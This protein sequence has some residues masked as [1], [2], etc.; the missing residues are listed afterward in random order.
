MQQR[1]KTGAFAADK[2]IR[3]SVLMEPGEPA[4][5][6]YEDLIRVMG[7]SGSEVLRRALKELHGQ[8]VPAASREARIAS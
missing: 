1:G 4:R 5:I 6:W 7:V 3:A 8:Q 2:P